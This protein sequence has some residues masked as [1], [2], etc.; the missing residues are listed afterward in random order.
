MLAKPKVKGGNSRRRP[1]PER[2]QKFVWEGVAAFCKDENQTRVALGLTRKTFEAAVGFLSVPIVPDSALAARIVEVL[3]K[4]TRDESKNVL[5][6]VDTACRWL[7]NK[8][9]ASGHFQA[10][11]WFEWQQ[12]KAAPLWEMGTYFA[13]FKSDESYP[14]VV[15]VGPG[16][17]LVG[18]E[19]DKT[20]LPGIGLFDDGKFAPG[21]HYAPWRPARELIH[22]VP[23]SPIKHRSGADKFDYRHIPYGVGRTLVAVDRTCR[24]VATMDVSENHGTSK[25]TDVV[26]LIA[27][28][29][30]LNAILALHEEALDEKAA[31]YHES[32]E[33]TADND[34]D[35]D[36]DEWKRGAK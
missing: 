7:G 19:A 15:V 36:G 24:I 12:Q 21:V 31:A 28:R 23:W 5:A 25:V 14:V 1:L 18:I 11:W 17:H 29:R 26:Q 2:K 22:H 6:H 16:S 9:Y 27:A 20:P 33:R 4:A 13:P 32:R 8:A 30:E 35:D 34:D 3:L 10:A